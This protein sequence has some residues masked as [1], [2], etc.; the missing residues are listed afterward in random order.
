M[1]SFRRNGG[2]KGTLIF[3][4]KHCAALVPLTQRWGR[5][6]RHVAGL[7]EAGPNPGVSDPGYIRRIG[8]GR[9]ALVAF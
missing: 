5:S 7:V 6:A 9:D 4:P 3:G 1:S 8:W 2:N